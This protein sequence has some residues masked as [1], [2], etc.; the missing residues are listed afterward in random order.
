VA[1]PALGGG[2]GGKAARGKHG[3][4]ARHGKVVRVERARSGRGFRPH[5][6][7][8]YSNQANC[9]GTAPRVDETGWVIDQQGRRA[10]VRVIEVTPY[11]DSCGNEIRWDARF[12]VTAG[13]LSQVSYGFLLLDWPAESYSKVLQDAEVPQGGQPGE[14][15]WASFDHDGD[16]TSDLKVTYYNCD[17]SGAPATGVPSYCVNYWGRDGGGYERLRQDNVAACNF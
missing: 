2:A 16:G 17:A 8:M 11:K 15:M 1:M 14:S 9:W 13:D 12:D 6:C 10:E 4:A 7:N 3:K 5:L